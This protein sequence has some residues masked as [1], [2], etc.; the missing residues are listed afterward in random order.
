MGNALRLVPYWERA[1][2]ENDRINII[3]DP[4]PAFGA[5]DHPSTIMALELLES[6]I[7]LL[8][9]TDRRLTVLDAG[10]GTGVLA[11]AAKLMGSGFTI[12][13][14][15]DSASVYSARRNIQL[16][17]F[18]VSAQNRNV[19]VELYVGGIEP[20]LGT[21]D[22]VLANLAAPTLV[23]L[24]EQ[25]VKV[26]GRYLILSGIADAMQDTVL[27]TYTGFG[28]K[29]IQTLNRNE[30]NAIWFQAS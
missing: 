9:C 17:G 30:W 22:L 15:I 16:N 26:T 11:I 20:V 23:R 10:T 13:F 29:C 24:S 1:Y 27:K 8:Y 21:F 25:F 2:T 3:V 28:L 18:E 5:G 4:G 7:T 14:D 12:G 19:S 6:A